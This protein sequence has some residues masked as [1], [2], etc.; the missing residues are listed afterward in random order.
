MRKWIGELTRLI[1][2]G[3][4]IG[5]L[6]TLLMILNWVPTTIEKG[7]I[8]EYKSINEVKSTLRLKDIYVPKYFP[9]N[10]LWPPAR[11]LAQTSPHTAVL[12]EFVDKNT[13]KTVLIIYQSERKDDIR[14]TKAKIDEIKESVE[15]PLENRRAQLLVGI[16]KGATPCSMLTWKEGQYYIEI[17]IESPP[18]ELIRIA[19]SMLH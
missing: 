8:R 5:A 7:Y 17:F 3:A 12:M 15:Y 10:I 9:E 11:I 13:K 4:V 2:F 14:D 18:F 19:K 6:I 16:C 1:I